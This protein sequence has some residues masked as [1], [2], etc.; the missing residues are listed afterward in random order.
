[1]SDRHDLEFVLSDDTLKM[2]L[3]EQAQRKNQLEKLYLARFTAG[4]VP[5][6][7]IDPET[8]VTEFVGWQF[9]PDVPG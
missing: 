7:R 1:M 3:T 6:T 9:P 8:C 5:V 2:H 4:Y